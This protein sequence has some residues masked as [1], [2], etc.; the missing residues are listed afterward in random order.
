[1]QRDRIMK[2]K[3]LVRQEDLP[4]HFIEDTMEKE[5]KESQQHEANVKKFKSNLAKHEPGRAI[6]ETFSVPEM[7]K[8]GTLTDSKVKE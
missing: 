1:M 4:S 6:A 2:K 5:A 3:G 7:R 8:Q